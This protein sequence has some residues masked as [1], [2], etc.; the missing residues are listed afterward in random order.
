M[1]NRKASASTATF[2]FFIVVF[3]FSSSSAFNITRLLGQKPD[4]SS[5]NDLLARTKLSDEINRRQTITVLALDNAAVSSL[6]SQPLDV[7]KKILSVHVI[8]DYYDVEKITKLGV[9]NKTS[10]LTTLFQASGAA[11][12]QQ[13]FLDV[14]LVNEGEIAFGS[15]AKGGALNSKLVKT[16]AE[17]PYNI[18]V[19]QITAPIQV[20]G[21]DSGSPP[22]PPPP[23][24]AETPS[25]APVQAPNKSPV[26]APAPSKKPVAPAPSKKPVAPGP[27]EKSDAPAPA[28]DG[29]DSPVAA[30][31]VSDAPTATAPVADAPVSDLPTSSA[32][33]GQVVDATKEV[34]GGAA[35]RMAAGAGLMATL[36]SCL[37]V[38]I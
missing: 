33:E 18:S 27:S 2:L 36:V 31:P 30:A 5:L 37:A 1:N 14:S 9:S 4:F 11:V 19:L 10:V 15:A 38:I 12:D 22:S 17:Q 7:V 21:I 3:L 35:S 34:M 8:L 23:H 13:G 28:E 25:A 24:K 6:S 26:K 16:V 32:P 20:P 29:A